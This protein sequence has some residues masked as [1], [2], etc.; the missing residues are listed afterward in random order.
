MSI[1]VKNTTNDDS[2]AVEAVLVNTN[3]VAFTVR[4]IQCLQPFSLFNFFYYS[5]CDGNNHNLQDFNPVDALPC[6]LLWHNLF[7]LYVVWYC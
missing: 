2:D 6:Y 3:Q 1:S 5:I 4:W 7:S